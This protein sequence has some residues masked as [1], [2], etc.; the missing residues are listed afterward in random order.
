MKISTKLQGGYLLITMMVIVCAGAG[1][2]GF[3]KLSGLL[4]FVTDAVHDT[5][6]GAAEMTVSITDQMATVERI[7]ANENS[8]ENLQALGKRE[9]ETQQALKLLANAGILSGQD[10]NNISKTLQLFNDGKA[11]VMQQ[12]AAFVQANNELDSNFAIFN[13]LI[14]EAKD[15]TAR[16]LREALV[17]SARRGGNIQSLG[18]EW[19]VADLTKEAQ[20]YLLES[21]YQ[22]ETMITKNNWSL[23]ADLDVTLIG[24]KESILDAASYDFYQSNTVEAGDYAGM[25]Y[26]EA[27]EQAF[28][29]L[30][31]NFQQVQ[32]AGQLLAEKREQYRLVSMDLIGLVDKT[33][34]S[35]EE[36][37]A[38]QISQIDNTR[39]S[40]QFWIIGCAI[41]GVL[42]SLVILSIVRVIIR[43]LQDTQ[44]TMSRLADGE[45]DVSITTGETG[46]FSGEDIMEIN[47]AMNKL[48]EKF[49][50]V[51]S[52]ISDNTHLVADIAKQITGSAENISRGA[53]DQATSVEETSAS[54]EQM[55]ATVAQNNKNATTTKNLAMETAESASASGKVVMEMVGAMRNIADKV[56]IIDDIAYQTNLL[57]LNAS[58]EASRAGEDGRG[59]AVVA[60]EVRKLAER[61]KLAASEVIEMAN[62]TVQVSERAGEQLTQILPNIDRTSELVQ[63]I[64]AASEEQSSGLHEITFAISQLD[65]VAQHN[66]SAA[67][68]LTKMASEMDV[69]VDKLGET[70]RFFN[71]NKNN[72][73]PE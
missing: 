54:I 68:Q 72:Q 18:E 73:D 55:S 67:L 57:A 50:G 10:I 26:A 32:V 53:N 1:Y 5:T 7:L 6:T 9:Q 30:E 17:Q 15:A 37:I 36:M 62:T 3:T 42:L 47:Q 63:E 52:Q 48:V 2:Y 22:L 71:I 20:I 49:T 29:I 24:L 70:I 38:S 12:H 23:N 69:S 8:E 16:E 27:F 41:A 4:D 35:V 31:S 59:F 13:G 33:S 58:I 14:S 46:F 61:S 60:A 45:L 11:D 40:T 65:K 39:R 56:S 43:W 44:T 51:V 21:K 28:G 66:A 64:S 19:A 25:T 34:I